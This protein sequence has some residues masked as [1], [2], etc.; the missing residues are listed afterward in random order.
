MNIFT[1]WGINVMGKKVLC[2]SVFCWQ[3]EICVLA[4]CV[5]VGWKIL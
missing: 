5:V 4:L 1:D 3:G 2:V